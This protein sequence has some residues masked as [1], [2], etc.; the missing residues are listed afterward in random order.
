[1]D[2]ENL[3]IDPIVKLDRDLRKAAESLKPSEAWCQ[4]GWE[5]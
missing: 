1:M 4:Q 2:E 3:G 5:Y